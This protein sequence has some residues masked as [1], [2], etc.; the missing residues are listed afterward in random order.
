M[1]WTAEK[2]AALKRLWPTNSASEIAAELR[3]TRNAVIGRYH[4]LQGNYAD[5]VSSKRKENHAQVVAA[6]KARDAAEALVIEEMKKRLM[7][8]LRRNDAIRLARKAGARS[9]VIGRVFGVTCQ[10]IGQIAGNLA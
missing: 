2:D 9:R 7:A 8:G 5:Y 6:R 3:T 1:K 10:R 4:R